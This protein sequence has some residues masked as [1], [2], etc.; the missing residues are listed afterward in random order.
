MT[1]RDIKLF[2]EV[3]IRPNH[4][5]VVGGWLIEHRSKDQGVLY[6]T[7]EGGW[8]TDVNAKENREKCLHS[9]PLFCRDVI[10][11]LYSKHKGLDTDFYC[12]IKLKISEDSEPQTFD[13]ETA[14][15]TKPWNPVI[16]KASDPSEQTK[17]LSC[18]CWSQ[19]REPFCPT[20]KRWVEKAEKRSKD[21]A[22]VKQIGN[23]PKGEAGAKKDPMQCIPLNALA[24]IAHVMKLGSI[25]YGPSNWLNS[26]GVGLLTYKGAVL[27]HLAAIDRGED[28]DPE[29]G[30]SHW[31]HI[32][33]SCMIILDAEANGQLIDDR[34]L[35][36]S[37]LSTSKNQQPTTN[38][39]NH[40]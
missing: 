34:T 20:C 4:N 25:K 24:P 27:R 40:G 35:H 36:V 26:D 18:G 21:N 8:V 14:R 29:S 23:D 31:A 32:A 7:K 37:H 3:T 19:G 28:I 38:N 12:D 9:T 16:R 11:D 33:A 17:C 6:A 13:Y 22:K 1:E 2:K 10:D 30:Q 5:I 39:S 15:H